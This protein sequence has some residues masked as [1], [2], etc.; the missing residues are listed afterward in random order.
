MGTWR[1]KIETW[2]HRVFFWQQRTTS[3]EI[4]DNSHHHDHALVLAVTESSR[5]SSFRQLRFLNHVLGKNER[6]LFW[7]AVLL[8]FL[9]FSSGVLALTTPHIKSVA[10]NGGSIHEGLIG[11]PK[12]INPLY[13]ST[14]DVDRDLASL[15]YAGLM[16]L[17]DRLEAEPDLAERYRWLENGTVLE[18][19]L[20]QDIHFHDHSLVTADDVIFTYQ[21]VQNPAWRSPLY[22]IFKD[23][24]VVRVDDHTVQFQL[25]KANPLFL[26]ELTL[27]ILPAH[28]WE[29]IPAGNAL[30]AD[31]N[32]RPI[33]AG[34]YQASTFTRDSRGTILTYTLERFQQ[35]H[36]IQPHADEWQFR[37]FVDRPSAIQAL[38]NNQI[39][40]LAF[41]PWQEATTVKTEQIQQVTIQLPQESIAFFN[42]KEPLLKDEKLRTILARALDR[43]E[44]ADLL[45]PH[46][47]PVETAFPFLV[48]STTTTPLSLEEAR[49]A[50]TAINWV[51]DPNDNIRKLRPPASAPTRTI[52]NGRTIVTPAPTP[53]VNASSTPLALTIDVPDQP[54]LEQIADYLRRRWSL[55]GIRVTVH[56]ESPEVLHRR[57][58]SDRDSYQVVVWNELLP[59]SQDLTAFWKSTQASGSGLNFSNLTDKD[60]DAA[61][62]A[63]RN[64]TSTEAVALNR[65]KLARAI[66]AHTP[67]VFIAQP[68]YTYLVNK[69]IQGVTHLKIAQPSD[70][71][72]RAQ[73]WYIESR[74]IWN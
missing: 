36:G 20:R 53:T 13:A 6:R 18:V 34:P 30:L 28:L 68:A 72:L 17:N 40:S 8:F 42:T 7:G 59:P 51:L 10:A 47:T 2:W 22:R 52:K 14:N 11:S 16:R 71:L 1:T 57:I 4:E 69:R 32:L 15:V 58:T 29:D 64:A 61:I 55:L 50:L 74:W 19:T 9:A 66:N 65:D 45:R 35:Y 21:A 44:L 12:F 5:P 31:L 3:E 60:V 73:E 48:A 49:D 27:G 38:K 54:D 39:D 43:S 70:R 26:N 25:D 33:G 56:T 62:E 37:F 63:V 67:A 24:N 41:L 23:I 46:A